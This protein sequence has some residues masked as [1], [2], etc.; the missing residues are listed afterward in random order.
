[1][2][3]IKVPIGGFCIKGGGHFWNYEDGADGCSGWGA[4]IE[5]E[6]EDIHLF[7]EWVQE[8]YWWAKE[9]PEFDVA[10]QP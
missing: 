6:P 9:H 10:G 5:I 8:Q 1:M 4:Y 2:T 7:P 3:A